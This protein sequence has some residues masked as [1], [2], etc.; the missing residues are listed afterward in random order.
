MSVSKDLMNPLN[1]QQPLSPRY[2]DLLSTRQRLPVWS[3]RDQLGQML[4]SHRVVVLVG[5]TGSGKTTQVPAFLLEGLPGRSSRIVG[6]TQPRRVAATSV[7]KR[8]SEELDVEL[9][10][11]VGYTIRFEDLSSARTVLKYMTDGMLLREAM[12]DPLL[13]RYA[14]IVLDEAHERTLA[15][16]I[17][18]GLIK[19]LLSKR[20]DLRVVVMSATLDARKFQDYFG[21]APLLLVPGRLHPVQLLYAREPVQDYLEATVRTATQIHLLEGEGD[22][23]AFLTGEEEIEEACRKTRQRIEAYGHEV[24]A[25]LVLPLYA[26]L[27]VD[28]QRLVFEPAERRG[29]GAREAGGS[30]RRGAGAAFTRKIVFATNVAETSLTIDGVVYVIDPGFAKHQVYNPRI[31][32]ESLLV[33]PISRASAKQR[34]GRAGR[35][36]P[37][38]CFRLYTEEALTKELLPQTLPEILR[39]ELSSVVLQLSQLGVANVA[40]FDY[41]DAPA[42]ETMM[43]AL[44]LLYHLGALDA[45][46]ALTRRGRM[47]AEFPL[48]PQ[49]SRMLLHATQMGCADDAVTLAA[50]LSMPSPFLRPREA[51]RAADDAKARFADPSGDHLTLL[52]A[53]R[54]YKG[55]RESSSWCFDHFL[56]LRT[57]KTADS[58]R[59]SLL[60]LM[61]RLQLLGPSSRQLESANEHGVRL[62][63]CLLSGYFTQ[64]AKQER[65]GQYVTAK[66]GQPVQLHPSSVLARRPA[67]WVCYDEFV[68]TAKSYIRTVT[69]VE[70]EWLAE[71]APLFYSHAVADTGADGGCDGAPVLVGRSSSQPHGIAQADVAVLTAGFSG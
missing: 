54:A 8:V 69:E 25:V 39:S 29:S 45:Q 46:C 21:G 41:L 16:D 67:R 70:R 20:A 18:F 7:S 9:G 12:L 28:K 13:S 6:C 23:L 52:S 26:T 59:S 49:L 47:M 58:V 65:G 64:V 35:T 53:Y 66:D 4:A 22:V 42:P 10:C 19:E 36:R 1:A 14:A 30:H 17:L 50:L 57:L 11:E 68:L 31:R 38:K 71:V 5:E 43:R 32:V 55:A 2:F 24:G 63:Q 61:R 56:S 33:S 48:E 60:R 51:A 37:G 3:Y 27:P 15:T 40:A 44:E 62:R 34:A